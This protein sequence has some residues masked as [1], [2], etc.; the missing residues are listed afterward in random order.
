M[1]SLGGLGLLLAVSQSCML[2]P[3]NLCATP[4]VLT[5]LL[6]QL[7]VL[8]FI[9]GK[10]L[11]HTLSQPA[12]YTRD[13]T[14][15]LVQLDVLCNVAGKQQEFTSTIIWYLFK[16]YDRRSRPTKHIRNP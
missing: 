5:Q 13:A 12:C 16:Y 11:E 7:D 1:T 14:K 3:A 15:L 6:V 4:C 2:V 9:A 8:C 10:Q